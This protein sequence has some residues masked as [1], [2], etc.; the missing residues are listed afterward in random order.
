MTLE[1]MIE[2]PTPPATLQCLGGQPAPAEI[3]A[4]LA[5]LAQLPAPAKRGFYRLLGP[6]LGEAVPDAIEKALADFCAAFPI[7]AGALARA[8]RACRFLLRE[9][10]SR[11]VSAA[12]FVE[13]LGKLGPGA[14]LAE[15]LMPGFE[16]AKA[17]VRSEITRAALADHG[18]VVERV[19]WRVDQVVTSNRGDKLQ[20]PVAV[21]TLSYREGE[22]RDRITLQ[23]LPDALRELS[24]LCQRLG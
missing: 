24:A 7:D 2:D 22:R 20:L 8:L 9:V 16:A 3:A 4:D 1:P 17:L 6:C 15:I 23:L 14:A 11:D 21:V 19:D 18:K 12:V 10:A 5:P 13:D